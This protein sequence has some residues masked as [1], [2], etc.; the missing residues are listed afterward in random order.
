MIT[1]VCYRLTRNP[2]PDKVTLWQAIE[3]W[4]CLEL[5]ALGGDMNP[6]TG[7]GWITR[8]AKH[9]AQHKAIKLMNS[10]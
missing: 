6:R 3:P 9:R 8:H 4:L 10:S 2:R 1:A 7:S 5:T